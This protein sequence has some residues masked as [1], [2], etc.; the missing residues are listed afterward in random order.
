MIITHPNIKSVI[1]LVDILVFAIVQFVF[2]M[3]VIFEFDFFTALVGWSWKLA[4]V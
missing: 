3:V 4:M 1:H 2:Q